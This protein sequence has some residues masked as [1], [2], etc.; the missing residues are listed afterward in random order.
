VTWTPTQQSAPAPA[1]TAPTGPPP[2][3]T[4]QVK[5]RADGKMHWTNSQANV[6]LGVVQ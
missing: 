6:D 1:A 5:S 3:A 4:H 2:G